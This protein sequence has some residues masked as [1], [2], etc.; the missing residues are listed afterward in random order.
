MWTKE[1][2]ARYDRSRLRYPSDLTDE[3]CAGRA[4]YSAS[5]ARRQ[6]ANGEAARGRQR[7]D[8][9]PERRLPVAGDPERPA[10]TLDVVRLF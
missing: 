8:V 10:A 9:H 5:Q 6:K 3:E 1:N 7:P 2:R 4:A